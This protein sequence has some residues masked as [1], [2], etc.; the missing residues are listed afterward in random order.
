MGNEGGSSSGKMSYRLAEKR[1]ANFKTCGPNHDSLSG[2]SYVNIE[3]WK[4]LAIGQHKLL[5]GQCEAVRPIVSKIVA[6]M[7]I[8][9][10]Q[11]T[12][13][14]AYKVDLMSGADKEKAE[15][16]VFAAAIVPRVAHC[17]GNDAATIMNSMKIACA[18]VG[19]LWFSA[20]N[21]YYDGA[22]PC[23]SPGSGDGS[24]P[25]CVSTS[26]AHSDVYFS[27]FMWLACMGFAS[28]RL[29]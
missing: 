20:E 29:I 6:L 11:G 16:A 22:S 19:V 3:L 23:S 10:I 17:N 25:E 9:L 5:M 7:S 8:P 4:E 27:A 18:E 24:T 2:N 15:G 26:S 13:R 1:C 12:L 14:Y 21:S 28:K